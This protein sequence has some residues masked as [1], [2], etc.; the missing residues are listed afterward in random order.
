[1]S[2][3]QKISDMINNLQEIILKEGDLEIKL[4][5]LLNDS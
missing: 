1:M 5:V 2:E 4:D 3:I